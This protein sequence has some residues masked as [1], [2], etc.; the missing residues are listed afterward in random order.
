M[1]QCPKCKFRLVRAYHF[2]TTYY[3]FA[4]VNGRCTGFC[5]ISKDQLWR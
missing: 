1:K 4:C 2:G 5:V 3:Q